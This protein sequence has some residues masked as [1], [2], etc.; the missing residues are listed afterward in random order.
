MRF[1]RVGTLLFI[2]LL[3]AQ[4]L[5][6]I[7]SGDKWI[8]GWIDETKQK[9]LVIFILNVC[10]NLHFLCKQETDVQL[11]LNVL[12]W[13]LFLISQKW[14]LWDAWVSP[15]SVSKMKNLLLVAIISLKFPAG[16]SYSQQDVKETETSVTN[17]LFL[18]IF[19]REAV[20]NFQKVKKWCSQCINM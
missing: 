12:S 15:I 7:C 17:R 14:Y 10:I 2:Y 16:N 18:R 11:V 4:S 8:S 19:R 6:N 9:K 13:T 20:W 1:C 5:K 3:Q